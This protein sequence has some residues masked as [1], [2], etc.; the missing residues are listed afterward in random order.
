[1]TSKLDGPDADP[2]EL[3]ALL[4][5]L[6]QRGWLSEQRLAEQHVAK[7]RGR[8]GAGRVLSD[9]SSKG[10]VVVWTGGDPRIIPVGLRRLAGDAQVQPP[11]TLAFR[12]GGGALT[13]GWAILRPRPAFARA[14]TLPPG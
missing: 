14:V 5:E 8:Y 1:M 13:V 10:A 9:L 6:E 12:R 11:I 3:A 7:A 4:D 2:A